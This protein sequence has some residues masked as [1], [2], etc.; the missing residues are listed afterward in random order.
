MAVVRAKVNQFVNSTAQAAYHFPM[1]RLGFRVNQPRQLSSGQTAK[2]FVKGLGYQALDLL[3]PSHS[4]SR[5]SQL[6]ASFQTVAGGDV[7]VLSPTRINV[8]PSGISQATEGPLLMTGSHSVAD[9][10]KLI[11]RAVRQHFVGRKALSVQQVAIATNY[12]IAAVRAALEHLESEGNLKSR[13]SDYYYHNWLDGQA[14]DMALEEAGKEEERRMNTFLRTVDAVHGEMAE[15]ELERPN[16]GDIIRILTQYAPEICGREDVELLTLAQE[17]ALYCDSRVLETQFRPAEEP[18]PYM[19]SILAGERDVY[20]LLIVDGVVKA[21][22]QDDE[23]T[24]AIAEQLNQDPDRVRG[25]LQAGVERLVLLRLQSDPQTPEGIVAI[26]NPVFFAPKHTSIVERGL[27]TLARVT[28]KALGRRVKPVRQ[29]EAAAASET[30][31]VA[32]DEV[33]VARI[34]MPHSE[35]QYHGGSK[36]FVSGPFTTEYTDEPAKNFARIWEKV[37]HD[38][39]DVIEDIYGERLGDEEM[40]AHA[41][42]VRH[43]F[44]DRVGDEVTGFATSDVHT[45]YVNARGKTGRLIYYAGIM[46]KNKYRGGRTAYLTFMMMMRLFKGLG[47]FQLLTHKTPL[48]FMTQDKRIFGLGKRYFKARQDA[49][50]FSKEDWAAIGFTSEQYGRT[51]ED[52]TNICRNYYTRRMASKPEY[53]MDGLGELDGKICVGYVTAR[54][55]MTLLWDVYVKKTVPLNGV[56]GLIQMLS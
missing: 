16:V 25:Y 28:G 47:A 51:L 31:P 50:A 30:L 54:S 6:R 29:P 13:D 22:D 55:L 21:R 42:L 45:D 52:G 11:I 48:T 23:V 36:M 1:M 18:S 12:G 37:R 49:D 33:A 5:Y 9:R 44:T 20:D 8:S 35:S 27:K 32:A 43:S 17:G 39:N 24:G 4:A 53:V 7:V 40:R 14:L 34:P 15:D 56:T 19:R 41:L 38:Y 26:Y 10:K 46:V 3:K 2:Y